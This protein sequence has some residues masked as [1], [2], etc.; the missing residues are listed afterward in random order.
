MKWRDVIIVSFVVTF[1][2]EQKMELLLLF[3]WRSLST[4]FLIAVPGMVESS[5]LVVGGLLSGI[6]VLSAALMRIYPL[7]CLVDGQFFVF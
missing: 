5:I 3:C 2:R 1:P 4:Q 7:S 6:L